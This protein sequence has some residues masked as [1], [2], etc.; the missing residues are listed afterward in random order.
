MHCPSEAACPSREQRRGRGGAHPQCR[1]RQRWLSL[2]FSTSRSLRLIH[3]LGAPRHHH[4]ADAC[5]ICG[6]RGVAGRARSRSESTSGPCAARKLSQRTADRHCVSRAVFLNTVVYDIC[7][8]SRTHLCYLL[9]RRAADHQMVGID[10]GA[11][12]RRGNTTRSASASG[13]I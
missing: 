4:A 13:K 6:I 7:T 9:R 3:C 5:A 8:R 1:A 10:G 2:S 12:V 11:A